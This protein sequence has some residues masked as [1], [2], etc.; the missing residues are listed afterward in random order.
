MIS[1]SQKWLV[2]VLAV[3]CVGLLYLLAP[4]LTP[5]LVAALL[6]YLFDPVVTQLQTR[7]LPRGV[8]VTLVLAVLT[9]LLVLLALWLLPMLEFQVIWLIRQFPHYLDV[10]Q[11]L[12][13]IWGERLGID[14]ALLNIAALKQVILE[15]LG[16]SLAKSG[17]ITMI[18]LTSVSNSSMVLLGWLANVVLIPVVLFYLLRDWHVLLARID[19][20]LPRFYQ[21]LVKKL[22]TESDQVLGGF[23]RGQLSVMLALALI[24][25][26][27]LWL[28][29]LKLALLIGMLAGL[30]SFVP[31]L[32]FIVGIVAASIAILLQ[33][34]DLMG[35]VPVL[36]VFGVGQML[37]S[38][39][40]TP[41]LVG[42]RIGL[43]PVAVI[44]AVMAGGQLFGFVG[45]LLALPTAAVLAVLLR[46]AQQQY[47]T[48]NLYDDR[49]MAVI[50]RRIPEKK[51]GIRRLHSAGKSGK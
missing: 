31:Y 5:F 14:P 42:D 44:F 25:S 48:S 47:K 28:A 23:L 4:V 38:T 40:L 32:G 24:Y 9:L 22:A 7:K 36:L 6:A 29:D 21:P 11:L 2:L 10:L 45:I 18:L 17:D 33:T 26:L 30:V 16:S 37:E 3:S 8:A 43:H 46:H 12:L 1:D 35:L 15:N 20:L 51:R 19:E 34:Q 39:V 50:Q 49:A 27:G 41:W 13:P